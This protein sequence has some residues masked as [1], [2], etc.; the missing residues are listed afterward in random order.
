MYLGL[1]LSMCLPSRAD[2]ARVREVA[3]KCYGPV[4]GVLEA[5]PAAK[6]TLALNGLLVEQLGNA[7]QTTL[8]ERLGELVA[9][10]Q[11][12]LLGT[13]YGN[14]ILT[15]YP[16]DEIR[17]RIERNSAALRTAFGEAFAPRGLFPPEM[18]YNDAVGQV[19]V[20]LGFEWVI[21]DQLSYRGAGPG[22]SD[23]QAYCVEGVPGLGVLFRNRS[24]SVGIS[25]GNFKQAKDLF[26]ALGSTSASERHLIIGCEGENFGYR[27]DDL[28]P[29]LEELLSTTLLQTVSL[30]DLMRRL[31]ERPT[32]RLVTSSWSPWETHAF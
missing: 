27:R 20:D 18:A 23:T 1:L 28:L 10:G 9:R 2:S 32:A 4:I 30:S 6:I 21:V 12:E 14:T 16:A 3:D 11:V 25:F 13:A 24:F 7:G 22:P 29:L 15:A 19:A 5:H 31:P 17:V 26:T 8:I